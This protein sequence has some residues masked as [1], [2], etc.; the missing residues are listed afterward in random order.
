M[1]YIGSKTATLPWLSALVSERAPAARSLCDPFAGTCVVARHFKSQG[2]QVVT[3]DVMELSYVLQRATIELDRQP[4]FH[5]LDELIGGVAAAD[6][7][8]FLNRL[9][10]EPGYFTETFSPAGE[11]R[12]YFFTVENA[13]RIDAIRTQIATWVREGAIL[14]LEAAFLLAALLIAADKVANT[15]GTYYA[16]LK[17]F[18]RKARLPL[19]LVAPPTTST[20]Q[21]SECYRRDARKLVEEKSVDLLYL[22]PPY[23]G[24]DYARYYHLPE[25]LAKG[26][27]PT[28]T[29]KS[30][31]P[32]EIGVRSDFYR[33]AHATAAL[34]QLCERANAR[35]IIV[36][37]TTDGII[38]HDSVLE[39]LQR[40]GETRYDDFAVRAYSANQA[41]AA[42]QARHRVYWC[43]VSR[44]GG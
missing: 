22:D 11:A 38:S 3:G 42:H 1:R 4:E 43:D 13:A 24:R 12:R 35:H 14:E 8:G 10:G 36:H 37:Y 6:P 34:S 40:R 9:A 5:G 39:L 44:G 19:Q 20:G 21:G 7:I 18:T 41:G 28:A 15:A 26:I 23:N 27:K 25:T 2:L 17:A 31:A 33:P 29:G 16:H 32:A 30:G